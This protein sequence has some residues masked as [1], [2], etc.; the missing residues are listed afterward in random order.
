LR[1]Q[2]KK[3]GFERT[4]GKEKE[5]KLGMRRA[6]R[7]CGEVAER[8]LPGKRGGPGLCVWK[9]DRAKKLACASGKRSG[10]KEKRK[11][12]TLRLEE[13]QRRLVYIRMQG[14]GKKL[15]VKRCVLGHR[16]SSRPVETGA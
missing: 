13:R 5:W 15:R 1:E 9:Y 2:E 8:S 7:E 10:E 6:T 4:K 11:G 12:S 3:R 16:G 14:G